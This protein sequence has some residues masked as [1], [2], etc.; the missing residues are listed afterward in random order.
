MDLLLFLPITILF[1]EIF[2]EWLK[3]NGLRTINFMVVGKTLKKKKKAL[4]VNVEFS[5]SKPNRS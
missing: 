1:T 4:R 2:S 5:I 3:N